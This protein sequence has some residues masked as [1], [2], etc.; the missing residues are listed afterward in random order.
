MQAAGVASLGMYD[1]APLAAANDA[2]WAAIAARLAGAPA[3]LTRD[4]GLEAIWTDPRLLLAQTCGWPLATRLAGRVALLAT[5]CYA[6][7]GCAGATHRA[8]VVVRADDPARRLADLRGRRLAL[9]GWDSNTGM[10]LLRAL[11]APLAG[12][13]RM[14]SAIAVTGSHRASL[15][16]VARGRADLAAVDCV[17]FGLLQRHRPQAVAGLR[18]LAETSPSPG[19]PLITRLGAGADELASLRGALAAALDTPAA[20]TLALVGF[21]LRPFADYAA[22]LDLA[23]AAARLGYPELA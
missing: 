2:L 21:E 22:L 5:P 16:A 11:L 1:E 6:L 20:R 3:R 13:T 7:P 8:F 10:N 4:R 23:A 15:E 12:G 18:R 19:L 17:T 14:F 9:N